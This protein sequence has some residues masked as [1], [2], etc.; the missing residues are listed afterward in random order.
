MEVATIAAGG[1]R[2]SKHAKTWAICAFNEWQVCFNHSTD[3]SI[4]EL[5]EQSDLRGFVQMLHDFALQVTKKD[6][7][8][9][10]PGS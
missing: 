7:S 3:L 1:D 2:K 6:G 4:E 10:P 8:L 5:S 9:Y